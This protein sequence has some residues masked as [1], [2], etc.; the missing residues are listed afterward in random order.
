MRYRF[1]VVYGRRLPLCLLECLGLLG[2]LLPKVPL[3]LSRNVSGRLRLHFFESSLG[4]LGSA[5]LVKIVCFCC[6]IRRNRRQ[7]LAVRKRRDAGRHVVKREIVDA[8][9]RVVRLGIVGMGLE[10]GFNCLEELLHRQERGLSKA[11]RTLDGQIIS[12]T[13]PSIAHERVGYAF[14][15]GS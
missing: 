8:P 14:M 9:R 4:S 3:F 12:N 10:A 15:R 2:N 6:P 5:R 11:G 1:F 7:W 13:A